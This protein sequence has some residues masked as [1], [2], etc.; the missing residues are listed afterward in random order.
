M[1]VSRETRTIGYVALGVGAVVIITGIAR[2]TTGEARSAQRLL[3][4]LARGEV[5]ASR[6]IAWERLQAMGV[7]VA[8]TYA[9]LPNEQERRGYRQAFI[10]Q[11]A[12][13]FAKMS[14]SLDRFRNWRVA[15]REAGT[16]TVAADVT[17]AQR[18]LVMTFSKGWGRK[19]VGMRWQ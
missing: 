17:D 19:L 14:G 13:G 3:G 6:T 9:K 1:D 5:S 2:L 7:D 4:R 18:T 11:F 15:S 16:V 12:A 8:G 10:T